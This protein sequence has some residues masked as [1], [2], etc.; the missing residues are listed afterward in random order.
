M[1][2]IIASILKLRQKK[3]LISRKISCLKAI[4]KKIKKI[5]GK[6]NKII[7]N[8]MESVM[9]LL[10]KVQR[11]SIIKM[12]KN[13]DDYKTFLKAYLVAHLTRIN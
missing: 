12:R 1:L 9:N 5:S 7:L 4:L 3:S 2:I 8:L 13:A 10:E 11:N 6:N